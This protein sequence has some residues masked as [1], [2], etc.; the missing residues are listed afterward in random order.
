[1]RIEPG[2]GSN[3]IPGGATQAGGRGGGGIAGKRGLGCHTHT[4][5]HIWT[6]KLELTH[7]NAQLNRA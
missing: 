7:I 5:T 6:H 2:G 4:H 3:D 1:M